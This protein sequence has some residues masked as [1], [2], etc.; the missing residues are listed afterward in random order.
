MLLL[1]SACHCECG[2]VFC[3]I[4]VLFSCIFNYATLEGRGGGGGGGGGRS[5]YSAQNDAFKKKKK[6][7][8]IMCLF[9]MLWTMYIFSLFSTR[10]Y[11][12]C[13][14]TQLC[15]LMGLPHAEIAV[16]SLVIGWRR[17]PVYCVVWFGFC[18]PLLLTS[19][20]PCKWCLRK[21]V[22]QGRLPCTLAHPTPR[23][24]SHWVSSSRRTW[25]RL[26]VV[27][28]VDGG[29]NIIYSGTAMANYQLWDLRF[30]EVM[31]SSGVYDW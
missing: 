12:G 5:F 8:V 29:W 2:G 19:V 4:Y 24:F 28:R 27:R 15:I 17:H 22:S 9:Y 20:T 16:V 21:R 13:K 30:I 3:V 14:L 26:L 1:F 10:T 25:G 23:L 6:K 18:V 11:S 7:N 31:C